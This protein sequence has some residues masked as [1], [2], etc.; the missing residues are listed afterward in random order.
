MFREAATVGNHA[1]LFLSQRSKNGQHSY[2]WISYNS[3]TSYISYI[4][5]IR[6]SRY[7]FFLLRVPIEK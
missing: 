6:Y 3:Y 7:I 4:S 1:F 2:G 5:Y